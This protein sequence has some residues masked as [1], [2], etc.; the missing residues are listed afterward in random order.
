MYPKMSNTQ[1]NP[2][3][4]HRFKFRP[5]PALSQNFSHWH[6]SSDPE[7]PVDLVHAEISGGLSKRP[8]DL[9]ALE[10]DRFSVATR[11]TGS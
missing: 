9:G 11:G 1:E 4:T 3:Q 7:L 6:D 10:P 5:N 2:T 8:Q